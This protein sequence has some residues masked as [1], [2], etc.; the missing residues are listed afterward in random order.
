MFSQA[1]FG[2]ASPKKW[3][4]WQCNIAE[5]AEIPIFPART[6]ELGRL[7]CTLQIWFSLGQHSFELLTFIL[8]ANF[9]IFVYRLLAASFCVPLHQSC[10]HCSWFQQAGV[11]VPF[12]PL[13][14]VFIFVWLS[15]WVVWAKSSF[16]M[17]PRN[18]L[19]PGRNFCSLV[20]KMIIFSLLECYLFFCFKG[21]LELL[22]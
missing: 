6:R 5:Q 9:V 4:F 13:A 20:N 1:S 11:Y 8:F 2:R 18:P 16:P 21:M 7:S 3:Y 14:P 15:F 17:L 12:F 22:I 10:R 19:Q